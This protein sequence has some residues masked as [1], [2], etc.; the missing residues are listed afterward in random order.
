MLAHKKENHASMERKFL[1]S[2]KLGITCQ[3]LMPYDGF[4]HIRLKKK[5]HVCH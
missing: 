3:L 4:F 1:F 2:S 5:M